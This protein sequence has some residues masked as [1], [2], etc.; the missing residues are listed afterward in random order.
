[1]PKY[2]LWHWMPALRATAVFFSMRKGR[3]VQRGTAGIH[4]VFP[5]ARMGGAR[6]GRD[7]GESAGRRRGGNDEDRRFR[8]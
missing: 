4:T 7:L 2:E 1:M 3:D 5:A 6:C 8:G